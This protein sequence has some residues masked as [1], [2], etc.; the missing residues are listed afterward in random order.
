MENTNYPLQEQIQSF[1]TGNMDESEQRSFLEQSAAD[2]VTADELAFGQSLVLALKNR[3]MA[4]ASAILSSVIA[5]EGFPPPPPA[6][7]SF[8]SKWNTLILSTAL[9]L[10]VAAGA[11]FWV[12]SSDTPL[13]ESQKIAQSALQ[14]LENVLFVTTDSIALNDLRIGMT[15]YD[16]GQYSEAVRLLSAYSTQYPELVP[17]VYIGVSYLMMGQPSRAITPLVDAAQ[18]TELPVKEAALWYLSLAYLADNKPE[19]AQ[20]TLNGI[21]PDGIFGAQAQALKSQLK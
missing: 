5:A 13:S 8:W 10:I 6:A 2:S 3:E 17:K 19:S 15:A 16:A 9:V 1:V 18:S 20:E 21:P 14:P 4:A 12:K 7:P 11:Y